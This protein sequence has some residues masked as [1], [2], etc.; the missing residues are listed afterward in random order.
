ML[1]RIRATLARTLATLLAA[2]VLI[3]LAAVLCAALEG[4]SCALRSGDALASAGCPEAT[5]R[6]LA[7]EP[8]TDERGARAAFAYGNPDTVSALHSHRSAAASSPTGY[9]C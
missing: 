8:A 3:S 4:A 5:G 9:C 1:S 6:A 2:A 7:G